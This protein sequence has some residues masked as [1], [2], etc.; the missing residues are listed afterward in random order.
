MSELQGKQSQ[1]TPV[2]ML[3]RDATAQWGPGWGTPGP[4]RLCSP[5]TGNAPEPR[6]SHRH[7]SIK[8]PPAP[9]Q[10][11]PGFYRLLFQQL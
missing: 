9:Q 1:L 8:K 11:L 5:D 10:R 6:P 2:W 7:L 4:E 3:D